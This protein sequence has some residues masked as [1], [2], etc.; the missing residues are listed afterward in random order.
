MEAH[1]ECVLRHDL[2]TVVGYPMEVF[3]HSL[4]SIRGS[5]LDGGEHILSAE[6]DLAE[7]VSDLRLDAVDV[8]DGA[9]VELAPEQLG[10]R[11]GVIG[12]QNHRVAEER[13]LLDTGDRSV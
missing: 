8:V 7:I 6:G 9:G 4:V 10:I 5:V 1:L 13:C 2:E 12:S 3:S 11:Q